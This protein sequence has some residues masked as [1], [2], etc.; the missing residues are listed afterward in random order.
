[1][2][3]KGSVYEFSMYRKDKGWPPSAKPFVLTGEHPVSKCYSF[4]F[5]F[6]FLRGECVPHTLWEDQLEADCGA[7]PVPWPADYRV[8]R[9]GVWS[10]HSWLSQSTEAIF[11]WKSHY[12]PIVVG[13]EWKHVRISCKSRLLQTLMSS[14]RR[15]RKVILEEQEERV[16]AELWWGWLR[17]HTC[18][19]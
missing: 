13:L 4:F 10:L 1:M 6:F 8:R 7:Y 9:P 3:N 11:L 12:L 14:G 19:L 18:I 15:W 2:Q 17:T 16:P 5:F